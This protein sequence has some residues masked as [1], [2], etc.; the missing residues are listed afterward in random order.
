ML[1]VG[2]FT[3]LIPGFNPAQHIVA[4]G[5]ERGREHQE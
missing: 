5:A 3:S 4:E 1:L 2:F